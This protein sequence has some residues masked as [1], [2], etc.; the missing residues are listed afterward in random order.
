MRPRLR[1]PRGRRG[2][3]AR[4]AEGAGVMQLPVAAVMRRLWRAPALGAAVIKVV[5]G[6]AG[7]AVIKAVVAAVAV[8]QVAIR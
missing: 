3:L 2:A 1:G 7:A 5:A 8:A 6:A 4:G